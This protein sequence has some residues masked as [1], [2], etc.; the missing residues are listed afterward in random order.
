MTVINTAIKYR[1]IIK[2]PVDKK[3]VPVGENFPFIIVIE[4][5]FFYQQE[6]VFINYQDLPENNL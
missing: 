2:Q 4:R 5:K 3:Q 6:V 1:S